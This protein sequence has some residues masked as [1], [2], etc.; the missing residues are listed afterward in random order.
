VSVNRQGQAP[1][2]R[3]EI[4]NLNSVR[5]MMVAIGKSYICIDL[6]HSL[7]RLTLRLSGSEVHRQI[8]IL[9]SG[10][11]VPQETRGFSEDTAETF[12]LRSKEEAPDYRYMPDPN[13][14]PLILTPVRSLPFTPRPSAHL[15]RGRNTSHPFAMRCRHLSTRLENVYRFAV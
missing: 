4:K 10:K 2:T 13:L 11:S 7:R 15:P 5:F 9:D 3:C 6:D 1:G 12:T 14:P 8:G